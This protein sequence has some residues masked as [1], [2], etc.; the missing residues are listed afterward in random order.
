MN[1]YLASLVQRARGEGSVLQ[2][3]V[4]ATFEPAP[5]F[6]EV[7]REVETIAASPAAKSTQ[8]ARV[9]TIASE[10]ETPTTFERSVA[11]PHEPTSR[12]IENAPHVESQLPVAVSPAPTP[13][14][15]QPNAPPRSAGVPP[16]VTGRPARRLKPETILENHHLTEERVIHEQT[17][18]Q[19]VITHETRTNQRERSN[20]IIHEQSENESPIQI[21]IGRIDVRA[22][23]PPQPARQTNTN[24]PKPLTL[25]D[26]LRG[27]R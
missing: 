18:D 24:K 8:P 21:T 11:V 19:K 13:I 17:H 4:R 5:D 26:Y 15:V 2:P 6:Q 20:T 9:E 22:I 3:R 10:P 27:K 16:A 14:V 12:P 23:V 1:G 25:D 7:E